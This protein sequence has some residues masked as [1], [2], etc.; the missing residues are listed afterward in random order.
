MGSASSS[1]ESTWPPLHFPGQLAQRCYQHHRFTSRSHF[2]VLGA[3][4]ALYAPGGQAS[5]TP[6]DALGQLI[7][8]GHL[9]SDVVLSGPA[10]HSG[11]GGIEAAPTLAHC[12]VIHPTE[13]PTALG[14]IK[15]QAAQRPIPIRKA[16]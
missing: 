11:S 12:R 9:K 5:V 10:D 4:P 16:T 6:L 8:G 2:L 14:D 7:A 15:S 1:P 3:P 13:E